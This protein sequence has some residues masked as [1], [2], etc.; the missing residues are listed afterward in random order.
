VDVASLESES[1]ELVVSDPGVL[2]DTS[3]EPTSVVWDSVDVSGDIEVESDEESEFGES[4]ESESTDPLL[5]SETALESAAVPSASPPFES[6]TAATAPLNAN[7][8]KRAIT[9]NTACLLIFS[10]PFLIF[11]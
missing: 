3:F 4:A 1:V 11:I 10:P 9:S 5:E 2:D 8:K 7:A 6:F